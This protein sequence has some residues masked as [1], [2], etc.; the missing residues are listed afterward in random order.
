MCTIFNLIQFQSLSKYGQF[1]LNYFIIQFPQELSSKNL[2]SIQIVIVLGIL[3]TYTMCL[4]VRNGAQFAFFV[5]VRSSLF[6]QRIDQVTL[7]LMQCRATKNIV[8]KR[9]QRATFI[10]LHSTQWIVWKA[11]WPCF[12]VANFETFSQ[13]KLASRC[14]KMRPGPGGQSC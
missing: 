14:S 8:F 2:L 3:G 4:E 9:F 6:V 13:V 1:L 5:C 11:F 12:K 7:A 10:L